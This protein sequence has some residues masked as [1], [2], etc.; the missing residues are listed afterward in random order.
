MSCM[1]QRTNHHVLLEAGEEFYITLRALSSRWD[2]QA[3]TL[4]SPL[5]LTPSSY[6]VLRMIKLHPRIT[7]TEMKK[8]QRI[9]GASMSMIVRSLLKHGL[10]QRT[11]D[12]NDTRRLFITL[13]KE[14]RS[15]LPRAE[16]A[17]Q[18]FI[19]K[20]RLTPATL[21]SATSALQHLW[22]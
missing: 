18:H 22:I 5:G 15:C 21:S 1:S 8:R 7:A 13:T 19:V 10:I 9:A 14:G 17:L 11:A 4:L 6:E 16:Q 20:Q 3:S 12:T 2:E